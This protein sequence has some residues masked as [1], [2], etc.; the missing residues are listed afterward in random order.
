M[1]QSEI[2][3]FYSIHKSEFCLR[4]QKMKEINIK[5]YSW[6]LMPPT[7]G[8][9]LKTQRARINSSDLWFKLNEQSEEIKKKFKDQINIQWEIIKIIHQRN[10]EYGYRCWIIKLETGLWK[11]NLATQIVNYYQND[12]L[13]LVSNTKLLK[14]MI[15]RFQEFSNITPAQY[16]W[17]KKEIWKITICTKKS[18]AWSF[19]K[20]ERGQS[21][22][23]LPKDISHFEQFKHFKTIIV[24]EMHQGFTDKFRFALNYSFHNKLISLYWMSGTCYTQDLNQEELEKYYWK[25][26]DLEIWYNIIP[27]FTFLNFHN[28]KDYE[29]QAWHELKEQLF[30]DESRYR[31]QKSVLSDILKDNRY[32]LILSDRISEIERLYNDLEWW[33]YSLIKITWE[34]KVEADTRN[35]EEAKNSGKKIIIIWSIAKVGTGFDFPM[36]D[37]I[38]LISSIKFKAQTIQAVGRILRVHDEK[39]VVKAYIWNDQI[40]LKQAKEKLK[41]IVSEYWIKK[42]DIKQVTLNKKK[43]VLKPISLIF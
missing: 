18:F 19:Y 2:N 42:T 40:L 24:D 20:Q 31:H 6:K 12:T 21:N 27:E 25:T 5:L 36:L 1:E 41:T 14:E 35:L 23:A 9:V 33:D 8:S 17:W 30:E 7:M 11:G 29:F 43:V 32:I 15:D 13:I 26:I 34:T 10:H 28:D 16:G 3:K 38:F 39:T 37:A 22:P 4:D